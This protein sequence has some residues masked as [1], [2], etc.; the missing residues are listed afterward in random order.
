LRRF[1][2]ALESFR[3]VISTYTT[4]PAWFD[5][6]YLTGKCQ[7]E[8]DH[9]QQAEKAW[10]QIL[11]SNRL[12]PAAREWRLSLLSLGMLLYHTAHARKTHALS[13]QNADNP[14][15]Q[16]ELLEEA[17]G[18]WDEAIIL[19]NEYLVRYPESEEELQARYFLAKALQRSADRP[20]NRLH[21]AET[22]N[23]REEIRR[24]IDDLLQKAVH[25]FRTLQTELLAR[26][27][28]DRL[29][30]LG[31][32]MLRDCYYEIAH[33]YYEL[34][35][36]SRAIVAYHGAA[37]RYPQ[38]PDVLLAYLQ[39]TNCNDRLGRPD[40]ARSMLEQAKVILKQ[41]P[42]ENFSPEL[43]NLDRQEWERWLQ[44]ASQL[45]RSGLITQPAP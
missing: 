9:S 39:M 21:A 19:L 20:K 35:D 28:A 3:R 24:T 40:R 13:P 18:R 44:W 34:E 11:G 8:L 6:R 38:D 37:N 41:M 30:A 25:E 45:Q 31:R 27:E 5:A 26:D 42:D 4:D 10:R 33:T 16:R 43:T 22:E 23:A 29:D 15:R 32:R 7:L 12:T 14:D 1:E 2:E 17:Y 36:F